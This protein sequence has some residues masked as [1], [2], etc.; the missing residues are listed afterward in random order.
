[1]E[2]GIGEPGLKTIIIMS[3]YNIKLF[4]LTG[5]D[6]E[7]VAAVYDVDVGEVALAILLAPSTAAVWVL[8][9]AAVY[10]CNVSTVI[11][12]IRR[13]VSL[14]SRLDTGTGVSQKTV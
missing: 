3:V 7:T 11:Q 4:G 5:S 10:A 6:Q 13:Y 2:F 12:A 8:N 14:R 9:F 1:M